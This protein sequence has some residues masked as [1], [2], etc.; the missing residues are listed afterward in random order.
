MGPQSAPPVTPPP[1]SWRSIPSRDPA[2][3]A[4]SKGEVDAAY[5]R[6]TNYRPW[7]AEGLGNIAMGTLSNLGAIGQPAST[8]ANMASQMVTGKPYGQAMRAAQEKA[9]SG[10]R[11]G[12]I[13]AALSA[14]A[15]IYDAVDGK[16]SPETNRAW[17]AAASL[18]NRIPGE[19]PYQD[20]FPDIEDRAAAERRQAEQFGPRTKQL[21]AAREERK[22]NAEAMA[23]GR[24]PGKPVVERLITSAGNVPLVGNVANLWDSDAGLMPSMENAGFSGSSQLLAEILNPANLSTYTDP[25]GALLGLLGGKAYGRVV[26]GKPIRFGYEGVVPRG[27]RIFHAAPELPIAKGVTP[28]GPIAPEAP[29][30]NVKAKPGSIAAK[31]Q[32][33]RAARL[34]AARA[35]LAKGLANESK[36]EAAAGIPRP[37]NASTSQ[38]DAALAEESALR[39]FEKQWAAERAQAAAEEADLNRW[40]TSRA[41]PRAEQVGFH[42]DPTG[43]MRGRPRA[44]LPTQPPVPPILDAAQAPPDNSFVERGMTGQFAPDTPVPQARPKGIG[45]AEWDAARAEFRNENIQA[46]VDRVLPPS[47]AAPGPV[48]WKSIPSKLPPAQPSAG[49]SAGLISWKSVPPKTPIPPEPIPASSAPHVAPSAHVAPPAPTEAYMPPA[50]ASQG[51]PAAPPPVE[52][53]RVPVAQPTPQE[54]P[55]APTQPPPIAPPEAPPAPVAPAYERVGVQGVREGGDVPAAP[56]VGVGDAAP[57]GVAPPTLPASPSYDAAPTSSS[58][59]GTTLAKGAA[60]IAAASLLTGAATPEE[61]GIDRVEGHQD[62]GLLSAAAPLLL[63][64]AGVGAYAVGGKVLAGPAGKA[65]GARAMQAGDAISSLAGRVGSGVYSGLAPSRQAALTKAKQFVQYYTRKSMLSDAVVGGQQLASQLEDTA[66]KIY[67]FAM[68]ANDE[69]KALRELPKPTQA[70]FIDAMRDPAKMRQL[71]ANDLD[72]GALAQRA[73]GRVSE[74]THETLAD[75][76]KIP[77]ATWHALSTAEKLQVDK[78]IRTGR[79]SGNANLDQI[80]ALS[81]AKVIANGSMRKNAAGKYEFID[82]MLESAEALKNTD[83]YLQRKYASMEGARGTFDVAKILERHSANLSVAEKEEL[84]KLLGNKEQGVARGLDRIGMLLQRKNLS[85]SFRAA[86]G[87]IKDDA[88]YLVA[89]TISDMERHLTLSQLRSAIAENSDWVMPMGADVEDYARRWGVMPEQLAP[90]P[91]SHGI[92]AGR[93]VHPEVRDVLHLQYA[94]HNPGAARAAVDKL[95]GVWKWS[96]T[97]ANP[98]SHFRQWVQNAVS[99]DLAGDGMTN[100]LGR[101]KNALNELATQ[102]ALYREA[103]DAGLMRGQFHDAELSREMHRQILGLDGSGHSL[104]RL[105]ALGD[106]IHNIKGW[107]DKKWQLADD[108]NRLALYDYARNAEGMTPKEAIAY[109]R[110]TT[111]DSSQ[112]SRL[113]RALSGR[114]MSNTMASPGTPTKILDGIGLLANAPF[115]MSS[116]YGVKRGGKA[117]LGVKEG[118]WMPLSDP[119]LAWRASK[120]WVL[121]SLA[122]AAASQEDMDSRPEYAKPVLDERLPVNVPLPKWTGAWLGHDGAPQ[123]WD[124]SPYVPWGETARVVSDTMNDPGD[125]SVLG[126][127]ASVAMMRSWPPVNPFV[128]MFADFRSNRD[129]YSGKAITQSSDSRE[130][131][132]EKIGYATR[133][134]AP[135]WMPGIASAAVSWDPRDLVKQG[136]RGLQQVG[137]GAYNTAQDVYGLAA[138]VESP[139]HVGDYRMRDQTLLRALL[140]QVGARTYETD[141]NLNATMRELERRKAVSEEKSRFAVYQRQPQRSPEELRSDAERHTRR[142]QNIATGAPYRLPP[143]FLSPSSLRS[144][145]RGE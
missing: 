75:Q 116:L 29:V 93:M 69:W 58:P 54:V 44:P 1:V 141:P 45:Q 137:A 145:L 113:E 52:P 50:N 62:P 107:A 79:A 21:L 26:H 37:K 124:I 15:S 88:G 53:P 38:W 127:L 140:G 66:D 25:G 78:L 17:S 32:A 8:L 85:P 82:P 67:G 19:A 84:V 122:V 143:G 6:Q 59:R 30:A 31:L 130:A 119:A 49:S 114:G 89:K 73:R 10:K 133:Q 14:H 13:D 109:I 99:V 11:L 33:E 70:E 100:G 16:G 35:G 136:G 106:A 103:R 77:L 60:A 126:N 123:F 117:L 112:M 118:H 98:A 12:P 61:A 110:A 51:I 108:A 28:I 96:K 111:Y 91:A 138:G 131:L 139:P 20:N 104:E 46:A 129:S 72:V 142:M 90:E 47:A 94:M 86:L 125:N 5:R 128:Q 39:N 7:T 115:L 27:R 134:L 102:G 63:A 81:R 80:V 57:A 95:M 36:A 4:P 83:A 101:V 56:S 9:K 3:T 132:A 23:A 144:V 64:A 68:R 97:V 18:G 135:D 105:G 42:P 76:Y 41:A 87:E 65:F 43:T 24:L 2:S 92:L 71:V 34:E 48:S 121:P 74:L 55:F 40:V 22:A 120:Y